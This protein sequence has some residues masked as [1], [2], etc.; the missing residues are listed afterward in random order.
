MTHQVG[1]AFFVLPAYNEEQSLPILLDRIAALTYKPPKGLHVYVVDDGST[2][3]TAKIVLNKTSDLDIK[4]ISHKNNLGLGPAVQTGIKATLDV[5]TDEDIIIIMDADDTHDVNLLGPMVK[6]I[7]DGAEIVIA[8][9]FV[10][11]GD[12][13]SAPAFRRLL[14]RGASLVFKTVLPL[15]NIHDFTSGYRAYD[16]GLLKKVSAHWGER[17]IVEQGFA[18][19]VELLLKLRHW[20]PVIA[21][22]PLFL[23]YERKL[24]ASKLKICKTLLQYL[25]LAI[26]DKLSPPPR[27]L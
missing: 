6:K 27:S 8:S 17:L 16:A 23:R 7:E 21:E 9:R 15:E 25:K 24:S 3:D 2:D 14:S 13:S 20:S 1:K 19:M 10:E 22:V 18:C 4:L 12:D 11:G 26:R 5:A